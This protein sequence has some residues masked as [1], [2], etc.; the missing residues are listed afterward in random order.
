LASAIIWSG[1]GAGCGEQVR[2][3]L[4]SFGVQ[5]LA[6]E[7]LDGEAGDGAIVV[8]EQGGAGAD[9]EADVGAARREPL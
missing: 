6:H 4:C 5:L 7:V 1:V 2:G 9:G 8:A 3:L